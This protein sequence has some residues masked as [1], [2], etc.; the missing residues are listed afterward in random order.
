M[1]SCKAVFDHIYTTNVW[2]TPG[3][4]SGSGSEIDFTTN[5]RHALRN[6]FIDR[7]IRSMLDAPCGSAKWTAVF[8][9]TILEDFPDFRYHGVDVSEV[10]FE[11]ARLNLKDVQGTSLSCDDISI[12]PLQSG[13]D[14]VLCR[15]ALQHLS[16][17]RIKSILKTIA[18]TDARFVILG[19]YQDGENVDI[20]DGEYFPFNPSTSPFNLVSSLVLLENHVCGQPQKSLFVYEGDFFRQQVLN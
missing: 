10:A 15:D 8:I 3:D 20:P 14:V 16:T 1:Q 4:G 17:V 19:G 11:K 12:V 6:L 7:G 13:Y 2:G 5:M 18:R 9:K